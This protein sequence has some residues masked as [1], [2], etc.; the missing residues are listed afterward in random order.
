M[1]ANNSDRTLRFTPATKTFQSYASPTRVT[2]LRDFAFTEDGR[3]CSSSSNLP[4]YAIE[5]QR[6]SIICIDPIGADKDRA[7]LA[8]TSTRKP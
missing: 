8:A 7:A 5:D 4:S 2:V 3:V 6:P 1:A